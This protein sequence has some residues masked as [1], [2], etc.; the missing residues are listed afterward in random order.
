[1]KVQGTGLSEIVA[2]LEA[3]VK[4]LKADKLRLENDSKAVNNQIRAKDKELDGMAQEVERAQA[5]QIQN[6]VRFSNYTSPPW[7]PFSFPRPRT[8]T[9]RHP[10]L[11]SQL[12][13]TRGP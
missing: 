10:S 4:S 3:E 11:E 6:Q 5:V 12:S 8:H 13:A 7:G 1:M 9:Q 2:T